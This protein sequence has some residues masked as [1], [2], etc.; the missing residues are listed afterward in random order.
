MK[1]AI[2]CEGIDLDSSIDPR[3]GRAK[4]FIVFDVDSGH[5]QHIDNNQNLQAMQGAGIQAAKIIIDQGAGA[6]ITGNVGPKAYST[7]SAASVD[8]Y[9]GA[10]GTVREAI[11][12]YKNG[13]LEKAG[14]A[15]VE[16]HWL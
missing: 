5:Y 10:Q 12:S 3:F 1:I 4:G 9:I 14:V 6:L 7:L 15:N 2:T 11:E 13:K 16:S 8:I